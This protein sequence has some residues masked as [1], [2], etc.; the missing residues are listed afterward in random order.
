[1]LSKQRKRI[2]ESKK[3]ARLCIMQFVSAG[4]LDHWE[5]HHLF[6]ILIHG[7][8][9]HLGDIENLVQNSLEQ[10]STLLLLLDYSAFGPPLHG[11]YGPGTRSSW[12]T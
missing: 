10:D 6:R 4:D 12:Q 9:R 8:L 1:M 7:G 11:L 2:C 3:D 5:H